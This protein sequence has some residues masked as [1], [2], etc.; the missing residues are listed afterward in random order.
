MFIS[1]LAAA[2]IAPPVNL[3]GSYTGLPGLANPSGLNLS[4][5]GHSVTVKLFLF[6]CASESLTL[7]KN[8][9][10]SEGSVT[11]SVPIRLRR[12]MGPGAFKAA[13][14]T[15]TWDKVPIRFTATPLSQRMTDDGLYDFDGWAKATVQVKKNATHA[16]RLAWTGDLLNAGVDL[17][18]RGL[19]YDMSQAGTW[20]GG[21]AAFNYSVRYQK[22]VNAPT[23]IVPDP[24]TIN[25]PVFAVTASEPAGWQIGSSGAFW[26]KRPL[27]QRDTQT[28][29]FTYY[30]HGFGDIG[31]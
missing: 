28:L 21:I 18:Q 5:Q 14:L 26:P 7:M 31:G 30:P 13:A 27:G 1:L 17:K 9:S 6:E 24:K 2:T 11:F 19:A 22:T 8:N 16:L 3:T 15:G 10:A 25:S 12:A 4:V 23:R 20:P 29:V